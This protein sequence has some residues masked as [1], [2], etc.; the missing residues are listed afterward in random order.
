MTYCEF[1]MMHGGFLMMHGVGGVW[2]CTVKVSED[3]IFDT[4]LDRNLQTQ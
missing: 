4:Y 3:G 2:N 1:L